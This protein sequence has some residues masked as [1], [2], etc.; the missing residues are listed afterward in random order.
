MPGKRRPRST[1]ARPAGVEPTA[2]YDS[3]AG[4]WRAGANAEFWFDER[5][6][7]AA[8]AFFPRFLR[9]TKGEWARRPFVLEAWQE[10]DIIRPLFG[11]KRA[12]GSR[13]YRRCYVW[14]PRKNGKTELAAGVALLLL[15]GDAEAGAEVYSIAKDKDQASI[16]FDKACTMVAWSADL[17]AELEVYKTSIFCPATLGAFKP[18]TGRAEGK[19]GLNMSGLVGDEV[20]E[21]PDDRL[22]TFVHQSSGARRQPLEF[23]IST[24]GTI[25]SYGAEVWNLC[26]RIQAG[27]ARGD[28]ALVVIYAAAPD[29]DWQDP[30]T[31]QKANPN[32]GISVKADYLAAEAAKAAELP[33]LENDFRRYHLNQWTEQAVRWLP[34]D[35]WRACAGDIGWQDLAAHLAGRRCYGALD[36]SS[37]ADLTCA[38]LLFPPLDHESSWWILPR[39]W[40]PAD[41]IDKRV[42]RDHVN[43]HSWARDAAIETTP[44]DV[45][46]YDHIKQQILADAE[47]FEVLEFGFDPFN[48]TQLSLQ[49]E[50]E[51]L[52]MAK[53]RQGY[54]SLNEPSKEIERLMLSGQLRHG[55]HPVLTWCAGNVAIETDAAG[56]IKP[57]KKR[58]H[59]R[60]DGI[61]A[62]VT[63]QAVAMANL[64]KPRTRSPW[65]DPDFRM[66]QH[67]AE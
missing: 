3:Q 5:A 58:S 66:T 60:I 23:L 12:D 67:A 24:A 52:P 61:A 63:A 28:D 2:S 45:I 51:G 29:D 1:P 53:V 27:T 39:F 41:N 35:K 15:V 32:Y 65:E 4:L 17:D 57:S 40:V 50:A 6:A 36:L 34:M 9:L 21:W 31:W 25:G 26:Q 59:E 19:H 62:L 64:G 11:W 44:G 7:A 30:A 48:A 46:D 20:H 42:R 22:Y 10:N 8:A 49:L 38:L 56:N 16:V 14:V 47:R 18:L 37:T 13:R 55:G 43:Y 33:R 54:L